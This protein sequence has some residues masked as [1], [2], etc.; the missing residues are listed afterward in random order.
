MKSRQMYNQGAQGIMR[1]GATPY[2]GNNPNAPLFAQMNPLASMAM[3][4]QY[5]MGGGQ[6]QMQFPGYGT[7]AQMNG[8]MP[9]QMQ[10]MQGMAGGGFAS[11]FG[12]MPGGMGQ[13]Q[14]MGQQQ[15]KMPFWLMMPGM[16]Q[17]PQQGGG[18][19]PQMG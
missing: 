12:G 1:Q 13:G 7:Y 14:Q 16:G 8:G 11:Q 17:N 2:G 3:Q 5:A 10:G 9:Q 15:P 18:G 6:G 4:N 19:K